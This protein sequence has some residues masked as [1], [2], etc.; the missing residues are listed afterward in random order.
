MLKSLFGV[1]GVP[2]RFAGSRKF[3]GKRR[4]QRDHERIPPNSGLISLM[5][6]YGAAG[7][8]ESE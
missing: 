8:R 4:L 6:V 1:E 3:E 5:N 2:I 7:L